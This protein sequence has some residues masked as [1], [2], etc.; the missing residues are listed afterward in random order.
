MKRI[1]TSE[2]ET[3]FGD[4]KNRIHKSQ[5]EAFKAVNRE[6]ISLYWDIGELI[7]ER[8]ESETWG[9]SIVNQLSK[10]LE[11]EFPAIKGFSV[12]NLWRMRTFY[13][14]YANDQKLAPLVQEIG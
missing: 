3:L 2:Y 4:I 12:S 9:K 5:F 8:Q 11:A 7:V 14:I 13:L 6:L 10:D 1:E